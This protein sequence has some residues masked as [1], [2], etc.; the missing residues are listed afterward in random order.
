MRL[1]LLGLYCNLIGRNVTVMLNIT[2]F[3]FLI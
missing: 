2:A 3:K 1:A